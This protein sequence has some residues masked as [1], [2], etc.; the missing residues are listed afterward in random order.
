MA[1]K[2]YWGLV[3]CVIRKPLSA[4][5][6]PTSHNYDKN[7]VK[8]QSDIRE[9]S[10]ERRTFIATRSRVIANGSRFRKTSRSLYDATR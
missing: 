10:S 7:L 1:R 4:I 3:T 6:K 2:I 8:E 9:L 5:L